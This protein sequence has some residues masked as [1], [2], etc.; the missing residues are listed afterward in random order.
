MKIEV[1]MVGDKHHVIVNDE[2]VI[3]KAG[4]RAAALITAEREHR[5]FPDAQVLLYGEV[6][7]GADAP[8]EFEEYDIK[9]RMR[10]LDKAVRAVAMNKSKSLIVVGQGGLGK[11]HRVT[12]TLAACG[13]ENYDERV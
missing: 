8:E 2:H 11:T 10:F 6:T 12:K 7:A 1:K 5:K 3:H 13:L 9:T 4:S